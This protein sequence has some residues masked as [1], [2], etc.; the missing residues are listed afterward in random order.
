MDGIGDDVVFGSAM[1]RSHGHHRGVPGASLTTYH[2][3]EGQDDLRGQ[4]NRV[5]GQVGI[6][7]VTTD[8]AN[9]DV[10]RIH[11][12]EGKALHKAEMPRQ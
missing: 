4:D 1:D 11:I 10:H 5:F 6:G 7:T 12:G 3:L 2:G 8:S 9:V